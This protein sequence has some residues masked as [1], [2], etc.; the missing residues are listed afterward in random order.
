MTGRRKRI[1]KKGVAMTG[2]HQGKL[3]M[4]KERLG[5]Q[6]VLTGQQEMVREWEAVHRNQRSRIHYQSQKSPRLHEHGRL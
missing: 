5:A 1:P 2:T 4:E 6:K 3:G